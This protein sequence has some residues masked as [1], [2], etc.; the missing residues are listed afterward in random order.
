MSVREAMFSMP[1][2]EL[3]AIVGSGLAIS[4]P[5]FVVSQILG[6]PDAARVLVAPI[7]IVSILVPLAFRSSFKAWR[8]GCSPLPRHRRRSVV[9]VNLS[10]EAVLDRAAKAVLLLPR[11]MADTLRRDAA[12]LTVD[13]GLSG[14][15]WGERI[16]VSAHSNPGASTRVEVSSRA[17]FGTALL[18]CGTNE[19]NVRVITSALRTPDTGATTS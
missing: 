6:G 13:T 14:P 19:R 8:A 5:L 7:A 16:V 10:Q 4:I 15:S 12:E 17:I 9:T 3:V 1:R 11:C 18:D 2:A